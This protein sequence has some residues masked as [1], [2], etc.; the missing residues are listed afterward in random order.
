[1]LYI[2]LLPKRLQEINF[3]FIVIFYLFLFSYLCY[4]V[5]YSRSYKAFSSKNAVISCTKL[6]SVFIINSMTK[7]NMG[8]K[9]L[10]VLQFTVHHEGKPEQELKKESQ[11]RNWKSNGEGGCLQ[12][13]PIGLLWYLPGFFC[14][15]F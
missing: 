2:S 4:I 10:L 14:L 6:V 13:C 7:S 11:G 1:M 5:L 15:V 3:A 12:T 8:G 9:G